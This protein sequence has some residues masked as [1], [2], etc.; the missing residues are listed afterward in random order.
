MA[1]LKTILEIKTLFPRLLSGLTNSAILPNID[2]ATDKY[3]LP[4]VGQALY[5]QIHDGY[6]AG[7]LDA[8]GSALLKR[9]QSVVVANAMLDELA[10]AHVTITDSG[11][12]TGA[13]SNMPRVYGWEFKELKSALEQ[14]ALDALDTLLQHL[15]TYKADWPAW[16]GSN[17]YAQFDALLIKT[18][19]EFNNIHALVQPFRTYY[20][21]KT[22]MLDVQEQHIIPT[23]GQA[24]FDRLNTAADLDSDEKIMRK[25]LQKAI[26]FLTIKRAC[27][28]YAVRMD[29]NGFTVVSS[30][31]GAGDSDAA[32]LALAPGAMITQKME[33]CDRDGNNWLAKC[34]NYI[35]MHSK[36]Q[37]AGEAFKTAFATSPLVT[38]VPPGERDHGNAR[39]RIFRMG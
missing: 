22:L 17:E 35:W 30:T 8:K 36:N 10:F 6:N 33:V 12:R 27:E 1:I 20:A 14:S 7:S 16:T 39:R 9:M 29:H 31:G 32:G 24:I 2:K 38:Y 26:A 25:Q 13:T 11:V 23:V 34:R 28:H 5:D 37:A 21:L 15:V 18:A 4:V 3:L 19:I